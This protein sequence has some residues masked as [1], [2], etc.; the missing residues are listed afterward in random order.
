[1]PF[2]KYKQIVGGDL[3]Q[4]DKVVICFLLM[5]IMHVAHLSEEIWGR[6]WILNKVGLGFYLIINCA[7]FCI[8]VTLFYFVLNK[9]RWAYKLSVV[10]AAFM[11][12]QGIGH[13]V[14][15]I[16]TRRY[17]DGFAGGYSGIGLAVIGSALIYYLLKR[18]K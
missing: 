13:N 1:M 11:V 3:V 16:I 7:L 9:Y 18:I 4:K 6:F 15:T 10:Y 8:P 12:L 5:L 14:G 17:F 2:P